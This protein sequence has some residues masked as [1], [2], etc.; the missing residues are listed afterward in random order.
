M[1]S[2]HFYLDILNL[3]PISSLR[4]NKHQTNL[5]MEEFLEVSLFSSK[6][7]MS[8]KPHQVRS[9]SF[10]AFYCHKENQDIGIRMIQHLNAISKQLRSF[11]KRRNTFKWL[12]IKIKQLRYRVS[13]PVQ[14]KTPYSIAWLLQSLLKYSECNQSK[15]LFFC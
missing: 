4:Y 9:S 5:K 6:N 14:T 8:K 15:K 11:E 10:K 3:S 12:L 2:L 13:G 7:Q 1:A